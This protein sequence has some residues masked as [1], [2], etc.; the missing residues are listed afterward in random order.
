[1]KQPNNTSFARTDL[2]IER[3]DYL[4]E[5]PRKGI[6][7]QERVENDVKITSVAVSD[8]EAAARLGKD[9]GTYLTIEP[10]RFSATPIDFDREVETIARELSALLPSSAESAF[11]VGLGNSQ[12][13]PD[14]LGP[15]V[16]R[17]TLATRHLSADTLDQIGLSGLKPVCAVAPGVLGQTGIES[18]EAI[19]ALCVQL[20]PDVVLVIDAL[21]SKSLARLG[22]TIQIA[23]TGISPGSGILNSR[24]ALNRETLGAPVI[25]IGVPTVVDLQTIAS[26]FSG[27]PQQAADNVENMMVTPREIDLL[28]EHAAKVVAYSINKALQP[29]LSVTDI[30]ALVS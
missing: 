13:T 12:I 17:Y 11:V 29:M 18:A 5:L 16:I 4:K 21:A 28:I 22:R 1:M 7:Q 8:S 23:D 24:K 30:A 10:T 26:D 2:A 14:A 25:S 20:K 3:L 19:R 15:Q 6:V 9:C 27:F